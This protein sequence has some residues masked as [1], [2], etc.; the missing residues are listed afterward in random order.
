MNKEKLN[1]YISENKSIR[2]IADIENKGY[3]TV[4]YWLNKYKLSTGLKSTAFHKKK[5]NI[6][7]CVCGEKD[8]VKFYGKRKKVCGKCHNKDVLKRSRNNKVKAIEYL[9]GKCMDCGYVGH[10]SVYDFHH[11]DP[12]LKDP[13]FRSILMR[14]WLNII[15]ELDKCDLLCSNCHRIKHYS[16]Y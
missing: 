13:N 14:S 9:G 6:Y 5:N 10:P 12:N 4:R 2:D 1:I 11:R 7:N 15:S 16:T 3:S 8:P